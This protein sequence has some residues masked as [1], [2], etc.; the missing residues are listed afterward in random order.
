MI[1]NI[2]FY[3]PK[4]RDISLSISEIFGDEQESVAKN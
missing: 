2:M 4:N 1:D 3:N